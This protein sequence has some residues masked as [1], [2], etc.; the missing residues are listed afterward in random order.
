MANY[1]LI[2]SKAQEIID[3]ATNAQSLANTATAITSTNGVEFKPLDGDGNVIDVSYIDD[4][5]EART[6]AGSKVTELNTSVTTL[7]T[8]IDGLADDIKTELL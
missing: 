2:I 8:E 4:S 5:T 7:E 3:K 1:N 6:L